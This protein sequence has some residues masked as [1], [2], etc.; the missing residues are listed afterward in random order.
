MRKR[1]RLIAAILGF[2]LLI[3]IFLSVLGIIPGI[4]FQL[5][6]MDMLHFLGQCTIVCFLIAAWGYWEI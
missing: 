3:Y 1:L 6:G 4:E 2:I 5:L